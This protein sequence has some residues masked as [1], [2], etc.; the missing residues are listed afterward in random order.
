MKST[1]A[2]NSFKRGLAA[3]AAV[4]RLIPARRLRRSR[5]RSALS[6]LSPAPS[7]FLGDPEQKTLE[8]YVDKIN[9]AGGVLGRKLKLVAYYSAATGKKRA[10]SPSA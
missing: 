4:W 5:S 8:L 6:C 3:G 1:Q 9:A 10:L 7:P 2:R